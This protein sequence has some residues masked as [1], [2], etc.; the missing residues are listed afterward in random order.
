MGASYLNHHYISMFTVFYYQN[1][2]KVGLQRHCKGGV[3]MKWYCECV[4]WCCPS[5]KVF[6]LLFRLWY[7][8]K[9][10]LGVY[11]LCVERFWSADMF[12]SLNYFFFLLG[13]VQRAQ[14]LTGH[15]LRILVHWLQIWSGVA[16]LTN[17]PGILSLRG[18]AKILERTLA[19][20]HGVF[21]LKPSRWLE[22]RIKAAVWTERGF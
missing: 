15:S 6:N 7:C 16:F 1:P 10:F 13:V 9:F 11:L 5:F 21:F 12:V 14:E 20:Q 22:A 18:D 4:K 8:S 3:K 17:L 19:A 2:L